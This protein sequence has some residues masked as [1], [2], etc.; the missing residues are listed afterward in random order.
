[1]NEGG[2]CFSDG[3]ASLLSK[4]CAPL[5]GRGA[6]LLMGREG[7]E[8]NCRMGGGYSPNYEKPFPRKSIFQNTVQLSQLP[9]VSTEKCSWKMVVLKFQKIIKGG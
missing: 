8:K 4:A 2:G 3:R 6:S 9:E 1:M 7:F 5:G